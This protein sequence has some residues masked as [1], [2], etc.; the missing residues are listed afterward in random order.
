MNI[1]RV[2]TYIHIF[3]FKYSQNNVNIMLNTQA[4]MKI[5]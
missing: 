3:D 5:Q 2:F 1:I 4:L